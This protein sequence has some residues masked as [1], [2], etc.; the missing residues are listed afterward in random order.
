MASYPYYQ[1]A[2]ANTMKEILEDWDWIEKN[3]YETVKLDEMSS[4]EATTYLIRFFTEKAMADRCESQDARLLLLPDEILVN[5]MSFLDAGQLC[6]TSLVCYRFQAIC[7][8]PFLWCLLCR[9]RGFTVLK[10]NIEWGEFVAY[11]PPG[12]EE[13]KKPDE[14]GAG[15]NSKHQFVDWKLVY[16]ENHI[17]LSMSPFA[18]TVKLFESSVPSIFGKKLFARSYS[19]CFLV[20]PRAGGKTTILYKTKLG[21]L[22]NTIPTDGFQV[23]VIKYRKIN[24]I[25]ADF[26]PLETLLEKSPQYLLEA[27]ALIFVV[28]CNDRASIEK[29]REP[30]HSLIVKANI[31]DRKAPLLV[32]GNKQDLPNAMSISE[33]TDKLNLMSLRN[34]LWYIQAACAVTGDGLYEGL[35]WLC[36]TL[37]KRK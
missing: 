16:K 9:D 8:E 28:D 35:D 37:E 3:L 21:E 17:K 34:T 15:E 7:N 26:S 11:K 23:E 13:E 1:V 33:T 27:D 22:V 31:A 5:I 6:N 20:G 25:V 29:T 24:F 14:E 19:R 2:E 4:K 32:Y 30:L 12:K 36:L 10:D 18:A